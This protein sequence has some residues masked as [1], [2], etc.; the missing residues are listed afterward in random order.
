[1]KLGIQ[2]IKPVVIVAGLLLALPVA[3]VAGKP[4][5]GAKGGKPNSK[6]V[7]TTA[8]CT[9]G[10]NT[11]RVCSCKGLSNVVLWCDTT[12]VKHETFGS[13]ADG[14]EVFDA[15]VDCVDREGE[16]IPGPINMVAIKSGSQMNAKHAPEDY[17]TVG[18]GAPSGSGLFV[19]PEPCSDQFACPAAGDC[20]GGFEPADD[21]PGNDQPSSEEE[22]PD[23]DSS[24]DEDPPVLS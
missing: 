12:W 1:M 13:D 7:A 3:V 23:E 4:D 18:E 17:E 8:T 24:G 19:I 20:A 6:S 5:A 2:A 9:I 14:G 21:E 15:T 11:A 16:P 10:D 22:A